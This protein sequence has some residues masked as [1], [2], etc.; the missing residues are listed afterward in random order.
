MR[1]LRLLKRIKDRNREETMR[2]QK[3]PAFGSFRSGPPMGRLQPGASK[4]GCKIESKLSRASEGWD[5]ATFGIY[6]FEAD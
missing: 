5:A 2:K 4:N 6:R 3:K 1:S